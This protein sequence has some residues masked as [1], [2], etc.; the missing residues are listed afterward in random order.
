M[1]YPCW[2]LACCSRWLSGYLSISLASNIS[3]MRTP[4]TLPY[5][6]GTVVVLVVLGG[7]TL[8][9]L[10]LPNR[11]GR[12]AHVFVLLL[13]LIVLLLPH[14]SSLPASTDDLSSVTVPAAQSNAAPNRPRHSCRLTVPAADTAEEAIAG[15]DRTSRTVTITTE[16]YYDWMERPYNDWAPAYEGYTNL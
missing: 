2:R 16:N 14:G 7:V 11:R 15:L 10:F 9:R 12:I 13:P 4:R 3:S 6:I 1:E 8:T 5:L